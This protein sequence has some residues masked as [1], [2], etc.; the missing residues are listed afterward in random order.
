M[1]TNCLV[2]I[3]PLRMDFGSKLCRLDCKQVIKVIWH[4]ASSLP[5][6]DG[7]LVFARWRQCAPPS[8]T[9][10]WHPHRCF[11]LLSRV[12]SID[13]RTRPGLF[14]ACPF[15]P[16]KVHLHVMWGSGPYLSG[17]GSLSP[18]KSTFPTI[19]HH[20]RFCRFCRTHGRDRQT[21]G[22]TDHGTPSVAIGHV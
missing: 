5:H 9:P 17:H 2:I 18:P 15:L 6:T 12:E 14:W 19:S 13:R 21:D 4:K 16:S 7:S 11:S 10:N 22:L 8:S 3:P 1:F 20:D